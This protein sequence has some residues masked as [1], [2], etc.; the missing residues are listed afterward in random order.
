MCWSVPQTPQAAIL[1]SAPLGGTFG[2]STVRISGLAPG[3]A[4]VVTRMPFLPPVAGGLGNVL[5]AAFVAR[6]AWD[7]MGS[8]RS[9]LCG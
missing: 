4:Y 9:S 3:P 8:H 5:V 7:F 6:R 1:I 2:N